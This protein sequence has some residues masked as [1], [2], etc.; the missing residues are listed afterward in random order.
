MTKG[1]KIYMADS[2]DGEGKAG[3]HCESFIDQQKKMSV[4]ISEGVECLQKRYT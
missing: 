1:K 4:Y 3:K 2:R